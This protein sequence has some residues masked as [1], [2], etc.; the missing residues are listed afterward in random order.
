[1]TVGGIVVGVMRLG[2]ELSNAFGFDEESM[3]IL[4]QRVANLAF[5]CRLLKM[6]ACTSRPPNVN[7]SRQCIW[8]V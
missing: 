8:R 6:R 3:M 4:V 5:R 1:M 7:A 2:S